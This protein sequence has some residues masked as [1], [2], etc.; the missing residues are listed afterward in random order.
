MDL[1][2]DGGL[3]A[4]RDGGVGGGQAPRTCLFFVSPTSASPSLLSASGKLRSV[5]PLELGAGPYT[6]R[7]ETSGSG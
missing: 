7:G 1:K 5:P 6:G 4:H 2:I 3:A